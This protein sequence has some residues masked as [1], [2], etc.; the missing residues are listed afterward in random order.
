MIFSKKRFFQLAKITNLT[1]NSTVLISK[2]SP[3]LQNCLDKLQEYCRKWGLVINIKNKA[4]VIEKRQSPLKL[5]S[6]TYQI[7]T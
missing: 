1:L 4:T 5:T 6:F 2:T 7:N 3:D